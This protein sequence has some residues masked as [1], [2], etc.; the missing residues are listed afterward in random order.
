MRPSDNSKI[1]RRRQFKRRCKTFV[2]FVRL[3]ILMSIFLHLSFILSLFLFISL[4]FFLPLSLSLFAPHVGEYSSKTNRPAKQ[5]REVRRVRYNRSRDIEV[6]GLGLFIGLF[7]DAVYW[8]SVRI[9]SYFFRSIHLNAHEVFAC[10]WLVSV[11]LKEA[12]VR[13]VLRRLTLYIIYLS[14]FF[15]RRLTR[16]LSRS[17]CRYWTKKSI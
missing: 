11:E 1:P 14:S 2:L 6:K 15:L 16:C 7:I 5:W 12:G 13:L 3:E 10:P 4:S 9:M 17:K 8:W